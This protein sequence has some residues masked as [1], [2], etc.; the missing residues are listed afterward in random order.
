MSGTDLE[1]DGVGRSNGK[2]WHIRDEVIGRGE[3]ELLATISANE[4]RIALDVGV[5][6]YVCGEVSIGDCA[7]RLREGEAG[8]K[9]VHRAA[10][11]IPLC[12]TGGRDGVDRRCALVL[13][14]D[15]ECLGDSSSVQFQDDG[16]RVCYSESRI[17]NLFEL[18]LLGGIIASLKL[19]VQRNWNGVGVSNLGPACRVESGVSEA[20]LRVDVHFLAHC[21]E[22]P[23]LGF[24]VISPRKDAVIARISPSE[25]PSPG[26]DMAQASAFES[27]DVYFEGVWAKL[28]IVAAFLCNFK[29]VECVM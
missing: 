2:S 21:I 19:W 1:C 11:V 12:K 24:G 4:I 16:D 15:L 25:V 29:L 22:S 20:N 8:D 6:S 18:E 9:G 3:G 14:G 13:D 23:L 10:L 26:I 28:A 27:L 17:V 5:G 7:G